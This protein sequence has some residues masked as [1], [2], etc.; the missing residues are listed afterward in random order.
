MGFIM[1][2]DDRI[3]YIRYKDQ[4]YLYCMER[5]NWVLDGRKWNDAWK[6]L[7]QPASAFEARFGIE[8]LDQH[9][10]ATF[11][12]KSK[13][14]QVDPEIL[15]N[16]L[17]ELC[18]LAEDI[19]DIQY[20]LPRVYIDFDRKHLSASYSFDDGPCWERYVPDDWTGEVESFSAIYDETLLPLEYRYWIIDGANILDT[21]SMGEDPEIPYEA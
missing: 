17:K 14:F 15:R 3:A 6:R 13:D 7:N 18:C 20:I 2:E 9:T 1:D 11:M 21:V 8:V 4:L 10:I 19:F 16:E 5:W 12:S